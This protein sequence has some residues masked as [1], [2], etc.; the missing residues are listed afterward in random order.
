MDWPAEALMAMR[1]LLAAVLGGLL[2]WEREWR[3]RE[4]GIRTFAAVSLG[5]CTFALISSHVTGGDNPHVIAAG[6]VTGVG[7]LGAGTILRDGGGVVGLTTA[8]T[9]WAASG[10]G[11]AAGYGMYAMA[12]LVSVTLFALLRMDRLPGWTSIAKPEDSQVAD[13]EFPPEIGD[14]RAK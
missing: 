2:G 13:P 7:F 8:A 3:G 4:A 9:L 14:K 11:L 6:V 5:A 12:A 1:V 10:I